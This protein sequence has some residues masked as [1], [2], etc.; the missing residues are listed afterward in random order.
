MHTP[1]ETE[2]FQYSNANIPKKLTN[3]QMLEIL[4]IYTHIY[5]YI[6]LIVYGHHTEI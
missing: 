5:I 3:L 4:S 6:Y 2:L 1:G